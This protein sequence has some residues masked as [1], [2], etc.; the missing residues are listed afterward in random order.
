MSPDLFPK[1]SSSSQDFGPIQPTFP[2][3]VH[4][5]PE[6]VITAHQMAIE[7]PATFRSETKP[8]PGKIG[9]SPVITLQIDHKVM[10]EALRL[11]GSEKKR[12]RF[13]PDGSVLIENPKN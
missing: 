3:T 13:L 7:S 8:M 1:H 12:L 9:A 2:D 11:S 6:A 10:R 5:Q 4:M